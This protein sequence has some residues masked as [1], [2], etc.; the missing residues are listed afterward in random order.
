MTDNR[1][2]TTELANL[3]EDAKLTHSPKTKKT[4]SFIGLVLTNLICLILLI[5]AGWYV[6]IQ[7]YVDSIEKQLAAALTATRGVATLSET[8]D[9]NRKIDALQTRII[10][11]EQSASRFEVVQ[12]ELQ[13]L[14]MKIKELEQDKL[15]KVS[16][17]TTSQAWK[18]Q[19][20]K[21]ISTAQP[22][23]EFHQNA[24]IPE[25]IR[26]MMAGID[27]FPTHQNISKGWSRLR[28]SVK[29]KEFATK[30]S[31]VEPD[32]WWGG[33]KVFLK[34]IFKVQRLD[35][36]NLTA[37]EVFLRQVDKLLI[38]SEIIGLLELINTHSGLFDVSTQILLKDWTNKLNTYQQGQVILRMVNVSND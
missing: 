2:E 38:E 22:L 15:N 13:F 30:K 36:D 23:E 1:T 7:P 18:S 11:L 8:Q 31:A 16:T 9:L 5:T 14:Q 10:S 27:F 20:S 4:Y 12:Q 37:E 32:G 17:I 6:V 25:K 26:E 34:G 3:D 24:L 29:F 28:N 19:V 35:K 33:F 21:A